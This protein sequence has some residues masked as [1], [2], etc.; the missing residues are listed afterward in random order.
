MARLLLVRHGETDWNLAGRYQGQMDI[1][2]NARGQ[3]Q[4]KALGVALQRETIHAAWAS[5]LRRAWDTAQLITAR[6]NLPVTP[7]PRLRELCF[8][9]WQGLTYSEIQQRLPQSLAA[10]Q[11]DPMRNA[12][13]GGETLE[14]LAGR[15]GSL[16]NELSSRSPEEVLLVVAHGGAIKILLCL[17][18]GLPPSQYW[19]FRLENA[20]LSELGLYPQGAIISRLNDTSHLDGFAPGR[21]S[22]WAS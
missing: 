10:W 3:E 1:P 21:E 17:A 19:Q 2:L 8:G 11:L 22:P 9:S 20:S 14:Q 7:E 12:P 6:Q 18:L 5:D 16:F 15:V 4:A 13:P